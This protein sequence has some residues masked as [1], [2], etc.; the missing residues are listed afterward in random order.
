MPW[1]LRLYGYL[2]HVL[3]PSLNNVCSVS[4][5]TLSLGNTVTMRGYTCS[6]TK[7]DGMCQINL[8]MNGSTQGFQFS[9]SVGL[10]LFEGQT[11]ELKRASIAWHAPQSPY[12]LCTFFSYGSSMN[13]CRF[14]VLDKQ[15]HVCTFKLLFGFITSVVMWIIIAQCVFQYVCFVESPRDDPPL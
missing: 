15:R 14:Y 8:H 2:S 5:A 6:V 1:I 4:R 13:V 3:K 10:W 7:V 9:C 11:K 12:T